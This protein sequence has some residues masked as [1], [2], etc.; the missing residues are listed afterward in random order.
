MCHMKTKE[1]LVFLSRERRWKENSMDP[2]GQSYLPGYFCPAALFDSRETTQD[3]VRVGGWGYNTDRL[4]LLGSNIN[5]NKKGQRSLKY[6]I[7]HTKPSIKSFIYYPTNLLDIYIL[8]D[9][10]PPTTN[11][12]E[13]CAV[14]IK[15][16]SETFSVSK[17]I[18]ICR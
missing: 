8:Q 1:C 6:I 15:D 7:K 12:N 2:I 16:H 4:L 13:A 10:S 17:P 9:H 18:K 11:I 5:R 14:K 3:R